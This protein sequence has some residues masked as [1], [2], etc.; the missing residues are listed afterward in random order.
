MSSTDRDGVFVNRV[1]GHV[2]TDCICQFW[3]KDETSMK[4]YKKAIRIIELK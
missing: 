1:G 3:F 2:L 4:N